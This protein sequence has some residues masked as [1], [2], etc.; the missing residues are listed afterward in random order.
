MILSAPLA[1]FFFRVASGGTGVRDISYRSVARSVSVFLG[2]PL[3]AAFITRFILRRT[4]GPNWYEYVFLRIAS[5]WSLIGL[6]YT[7]VVLFA[8]QGHQAFDHILVSVA[9]VA[10]PLLVY[11]VMIFFITLFV[12]YKFGSSYPVAVTQSFTASSNDFG[13]AITVAAATFGPG[14]D[15]ALAS[16]VGPLIEVPVLIGLINAMRWIRKRWIR[17]D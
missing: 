6:L 16:T 15:Q 1:F 10:A 8:C 3:A 2:H 9:R 17:K 4:G 11:F 12:T 14:S 7:V 5:F 13:L